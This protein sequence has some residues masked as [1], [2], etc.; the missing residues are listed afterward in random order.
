MPPTSPT[1]AL[2]VEQPGRIKDT[3]KTTML[4]IVHATSFFM[5]NLLNRVWQLLGCLPIVSDITRQDCN[6]FWKKLTFALAGIA[7]AV[8]HHHMTISEP[9]VCANQWSFASVVYRPASLLGA[10]RSF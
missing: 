2:P 6:R 1:A 4:K 9:I 7:T 3:A 5:I 8:Y 10:G